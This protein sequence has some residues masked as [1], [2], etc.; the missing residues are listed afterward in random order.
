MTDM[1]EEKCFCHLED[2]EGNVYQVKDKTAR[3]AIQAHE[4]LLQGLMEG[5]SE[6]SSAQFF[7]LT[8]DNPEIEVGNSLVF[9]LDWKTSAIESYYNVANSSFSGQYFRILAPNKTI[10]FTPFTFTHHEGKVTMSSTGP[11]SYCA[12]VCVLNGVSGGSGGSGGSGDPVD[13]SAIEEALQDLNT[14]LETVEAND[15][16][17]VDLST[18]EAEIEFLKTSNTMLNTSIGNLQSQIS[19]LHNEILQLKAN[20]GTGGDTPSDPNLISFTILGVTYQA[21]SG[22]N[23]GEWVESEYNTNNFFVA[24]ST[25]TIHKG[26]YQ[27]MTGDTNVKATDEI[28]SGYTYQTYN[29]TPD[30][31]G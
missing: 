11:T 19:V 27:I 25:N 29:K 26:D 22:M 4:V 6:G 10:S 21:E 28:I 3:E 18:V 23:W 16:D 31:P 2:K 30:M 17:P 13:L 20:A 12:L 7:L 1:S 15:H 9:L 8:Q 5:S 14:R 24:S